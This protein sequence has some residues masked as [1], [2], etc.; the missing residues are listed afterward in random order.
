MRVTLTCDAVGGIWTHSLDLASGLKYLGWE[1]SL[2][3]FGPHP[4]DEQMRQADAA[5]LASLHHVPTSLEWTPDPWDQLEDAADRLAQ[6]VDEQRPHVLHLNS[7]HPA[8]R[9]WPVPVVLGAHS[10]VLSWWRG[11]K[12]VPAPPEWDRYAWAVTMG[13]AGADAVVAPTHSMLRQL[14]EAYAHAPCCGWSTTV[15]HNGRGGFGPGREKRRPVV[16]SVGRAWDEAKNVETVDR[17][18][19]ML[20]VPVE[21]AGAGT[22]S[23][24][25]ARGL[26]LLP[27]SQLAERLGEAAVFL[28]PAR[29]EPFGLAVLEAALSGCALVLSDIPSFRELWSGVALFSPPDDAT[30]F[31]THVE[32]LLDDGQLR[33]RLSSSA[34]ARASTMT[35]EAMARA[36][37]ELYTRLM[38]RARVPVTT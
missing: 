33:Q 20:P 13:L 30:A 14:K 6:I 35:V 19:S 11:V 27:T 37:S 1:V 15:I 2:V 16:I 17:I 34:R 29:Y 26:G 36:Y 21:V 31:T 10:C 23:L 12:E 25:H 4:S 8:G 24:T 28:S 38:H 22:E 3:V 18:A 7:Y 5:T 9:S 32:G